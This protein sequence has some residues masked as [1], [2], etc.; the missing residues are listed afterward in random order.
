MALGF[1]IAE[2]TPNPAPA[3]DGATA[4]HADHVGYSLATARPARRPKKAPSPSDAPL[5]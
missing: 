1:T 3:P 2:S 4:L 5:A